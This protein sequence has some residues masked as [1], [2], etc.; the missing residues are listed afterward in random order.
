MENE[1]FNLSDPFEKAVSERLESYMND[2]SDHDTV[3]K[4]IYRDFPNMDGELVNKCADA[5]YK[6]YF[7]GKED[8]HTV[9][10]IKDV[11]VVH[12]NHLDIRILFFQIASCAG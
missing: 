2:G 3:L 8:T 9:A 6:R 11:L 5:A 10:S 12:G 4:L 1:F 7:C